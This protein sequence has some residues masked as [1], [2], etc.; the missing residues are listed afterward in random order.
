MRARGHIVP[1]ASIF[2]HGRFLI[3]YVVPCKLRL[4]FQLHV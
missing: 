2:V 3:L 1:L 4:G